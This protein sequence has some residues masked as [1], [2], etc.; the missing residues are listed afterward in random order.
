M[1]HVM[2]DSSVVRAHA[3]AAGAKGGS[4]IRH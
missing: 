1:E 3:C 2:I 4:R